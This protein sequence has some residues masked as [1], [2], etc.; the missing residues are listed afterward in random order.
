M[1]AFG[2]QSDPR[3]VHNIGMQGN[4]DQARFGP[5][6][7]THLIERMENAGLTRSMSKKV[8]LQTTQLVKDFSAGRKTRC[9][10][11]VSFQI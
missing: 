3:S 6:S 7:Y 11:V 5:V 1:K 9:F 10:I 2:Y 8:V 4:R